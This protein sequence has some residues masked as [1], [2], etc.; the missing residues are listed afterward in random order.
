MT[1]NSHVNMDNMTISLEDAMQLVRGNAVAT[2]VK[3]LPWLE[4]IVGVPVYAKMEFQQHTGSFKYRGALCAL[5]HRRSDL[6]SRQEMKPKKELI[7]A[8]YISSFI[9]FC[10]IYRG[11]F[12]YNIIYIAT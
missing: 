3:R 6:Y 5:A 1:F 4:K 9:S 8:T 11:N 10:S 12:F 7:S 2:P